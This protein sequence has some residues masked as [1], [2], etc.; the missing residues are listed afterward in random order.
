MRVK[1]LELARATAQP[2]QD[3]RLG[4]LARPLGR[5]GQELS[6]RRQ[7]T[8]PGQLQKAAAGEYGFARKSHHEP[9]LV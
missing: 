5:F 7:P 9:H 3:H 2:E 8:D 4:R 1:R 6:D